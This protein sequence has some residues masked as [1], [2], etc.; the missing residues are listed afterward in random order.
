VVG[1]LVIVAAAAASVAV[2]GAAC[3][4]GKCLPNRFSFSIFNFNRLLYDRKKGELI[5]LLLLCLF[6]V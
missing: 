1:W 4:L 5:V 3:M 6:V 2:T